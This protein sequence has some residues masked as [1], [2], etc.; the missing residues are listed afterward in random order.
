MEQMHQMIQNVGKSIEM[1]DMERKDFEA[2]VKLYEAE[3]K[4]IAAVQAG[5]SEQQIQDIAMGV[6]A[7]AMESQNMMNQMPEMREE[8]MPMEMMPSQP[9]MEPM[10]PQGMPQ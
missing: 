10:P 1:Q 7:A 3:T 2:E 9:E 5:M 4:R 6:V 8:S